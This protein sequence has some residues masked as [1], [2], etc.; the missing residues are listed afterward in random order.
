MH[1]LDGESPSIQE[2]DSIP[3]K[4]WE[5]LAALEFTNG[6]SFEDMS[7]MLGKEYNEVSTFITSSR[8][9]KAVQTILRMDPERLQNVVDAAAYDSIVAL[10]KIRDLG[11]NESA[12]ITAANSLLERVLPRLQNKKHSGRVITPHRPGE[13][14]EDE[15][16]RL[17]DE[18]KSVS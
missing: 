10:I 17:R 11:R 4:P 13:S 8:G 9:V 12:R 3:I 16:A 7:K 14:L 1:L 15:I 2:N 18:I 6:T 5:R